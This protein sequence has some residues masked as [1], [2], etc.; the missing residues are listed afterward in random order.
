MSQ[1]D[2]SPEALT[3][4]AR[5]LGFLQGFARETAVSGGALILSGDPGMGKTA[6]LGALAD[7]ALTSGMTVLRVAGLE[8]EG[9]VSF[10]T[11]NQALFPLLGDLDELASAHRDAL[12]V[13]L[14]FG[15]GSPP[16]RLLVSTATLVLLRHVAARAP[17]LLIVD[18]LPWIDRAS[19]GVLS[20]VARR[21]AGS[22]AGLLGARRTGAQ[23]YFERAGLPDY[24]LK[25]LDDHAAAQLVASRFPG[26]D[27]QV[28]NRVLQAA[29]GN[30][31]ALLELPQA[32]TEAQRS[33][34]GAASLGAAARPAPAGA[35]HLTRRPAP[36]PDPGAPPRGGP[37]RYGGPSGA[38]CGGRPRL[39]AR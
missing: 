24:E 5:E 36:S 33:G 39:P 12:R 15:A 29:Q 13:A 34:Q 14:G 19:A 6:L 32:L 25:P 27:P 10:A 35:V 37:G 22:R 9:E 7:S 3:G 2:L 23:T 31:L 38:G 20:F 4:R 16:D 8:F 18:D 30:P 17:L 1:L 21:L 28:R 26:I 11:L